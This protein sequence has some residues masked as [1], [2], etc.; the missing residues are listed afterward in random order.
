MNTQPARDPFKIFLG[1]LLVCL[2]T[3]MAVKGFPTPTPI[4]LAPTHGTGGPLLP[5]HEPVQNGLPWEV[6]VRYFQFLLLSL[7]TVNI[8]VVLV[9]SG[10][11]SQGA[12]SQPA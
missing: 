12:R 8:G 1:V 5:G 7:A 6:F 3:F 9:Y 2:G 10:L 4:I 11:T